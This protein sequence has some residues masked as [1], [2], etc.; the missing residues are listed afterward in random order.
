MANRFWVGTSLDWHTAANWAATSGGAGG[1]GVPTASDDVFFDAN[2][3]ALCWAAAPIAVNNLTMQ[4]TCS[5]ILLLIEQG[6][7]INGDFLQDE[8]YFGPFG[9]G[10]YVVEFKGNWRSNAG[11]F[12][13]GTG[14]GVDPTCLFSGASKTYILDNL[15]AASYQNFS[16]SGTYTMSGTRLAVA[17]IQ[18]EISVTG[19]MTIALGNRVDLNGISASWGTFTGEITGQGQFHYTYRASSTMSTTGTITVATFTYYI[20]AT[21]VTITARRYLSPCTVEIEFTGDQTVRLDNNDRHYFL[22]HLEIKSSGSL[23]AATLDMDFNK[24]EI[25]VHGTTDIDNNS[26]TGALFTLKLG[27]GIHVFRGTIDFFFQTGSSGNR[28]AVDAGR[29]TVFLWPRGLRLIPIP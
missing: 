17:T 25:W 18:Q 14:T 5:H 13:V 9:G 11:S 23:T 24:A 26:F 7:V 22:G 16:M 8:G 10:G 1:A 20:N 2:G 4:A 19:T 27:D 3:Q 12:S 29:G 6:G 28:L 15:S 21:P